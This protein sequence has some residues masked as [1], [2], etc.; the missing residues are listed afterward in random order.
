MRE[1][2]C[3]VSTWRGRLNCPNGACPSRNSSQSKERR[4]LQG[5]PPKCTRRFQKSRHPFASHREQNP[6]GQPEEESARFFA[7]RERGCQ[8]KWH[9]LAKLAKSFGGWI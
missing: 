1:T 8:P 9:I 7:E 3:R 2:L 5:R 6:P 4:G